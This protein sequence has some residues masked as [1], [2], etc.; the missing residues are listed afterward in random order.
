MSSKCIA[1][2]HKKYVKFPIRNKTD[3]LKIKIKAS[4]S[5]NVVPIKTWNTVTFKKVVAVMKSDIF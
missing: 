2:Y 3:K 5:K 1:V 4:F